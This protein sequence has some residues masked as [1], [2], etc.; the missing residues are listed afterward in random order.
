MDKWGHSKQGESVSKGRDKEHVFVWGM[1][2]NEPRWSVEVTGDRCEKAG[3][4]RQ[5]TLND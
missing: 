2:G 4:P 1:R 3:C 5:E